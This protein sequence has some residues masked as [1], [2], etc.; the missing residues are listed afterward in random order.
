MRRTA[1]FCRAFALCLAAFLLHGTPARPADAGRPIELSVDATEAARKLLHA[2]L[3]IPAAP[4]PLT[5]Y[6]P[7]W[8][9]GEHMPNGPINDLSG[10]K[11]QAGGRP[12][13]WRRDDLDLYAFH[14][15]VPEGADAVEVTLDYLGPTAKEGFSASA[16]MTARL[17]ILNWHLVL[18]YPKTAPVR[19]QRVRA[20][21]TLPK[22]WKLGTALPIEA[23]R[24]AVT[25]FQTVS[26]ETLAD[27]TVLC[28][29]YLKEERLGP[30]GGPPHYLVLA[31][32]SPAGLELNAALKSQYERLVAE[33]GALFGAR[34]YRSYRFLV[35]MSDHIRPSGIEHHEC[36]DD[37]VPERFLLD[38]TYRKLWSAWLLPHE[39]VHSWNGKYR[40]PAGLATSD[41]QQPMKTRL[42]WVYE[43][44]TEYL[45]FVLAGRS[46]LY[47]PDLSRENL[48]VVAD[49][50]RNQVGRTWR[51]LE[52]TTAAAPDLYA[53]RS[54]W[55]HRRR[56]V[57]FY[58]EGALLWLDAD[59]LIRE[60]T[61]GKKSL[62]D[63]CRAF[64]GGQ[65]GPPD[66]KPYTFDD[67]VQ[68]LNHVV[69][70][71]WKGFLEQRLTAKSPEP[72]LDGLKRAG[73]KLVYRDKPGELLK[74]RD[75]EAKTVDLTTALGLLLKDD[76]TVIDVVSGKAADRAGVGPS[77]K[78]VAVNG[79]RWSAE[80]LRH[81]VAG[82]QRGEKLSLLL[83]NG[84]YFQTVTLDY[85][86]GE[87]YPHL[88]RDPSKRDLLE[89]IFRPRTG[90]PSP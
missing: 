64:H 53:S 84:D 15:T 60:K 46:G 76:G 43:G 41:F 28:G 86:D 74:A 77:M 45:G 82:T 73:W 47:T 30:A 51:P 58:D 56:G 36:S 67:V 38:D 22:G 78:L 18:V 1:L 52:D 5:L 85:A 81:A 34:H 68:T 16:S 66:V 48:A 9:Q 54:D 37:R 3:I 80:R 75:G 14:C 59:T 49:W 50:A 69:E 7:K 13:P 4:G 20:S 65:D 71:D 23:T 42:L 70:H 40:R 8:I 19:Q 87:Q 21:L 12:V 88:E 33:A 10:L 57:D 44:L 6:Y 90:M 35:T 39:Y 29:A 89:D 2:R 61:D 17:A 63:F 31:C 32:D 24:E 11:I 62:D 83:E 55:S 72:P 79:R 26:L 27:S 25:Q